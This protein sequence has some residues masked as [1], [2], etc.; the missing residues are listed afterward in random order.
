VAVEVMPEG[1]P[2][3]WW[4][5]NPK[6]GCWWLG[7]W[8]GGSGVFV[9]MVII[10]SKLIIMKEQQVRKNCQSFM[11]KLQNTNAY[12]SVK[13]LLLCWKRQEK[14]HNFVAA[15]DAFIKI[16]RTVYEFSQEEKDDKLI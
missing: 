8:E 7:D 11:N 6:G 4:R 10:N 15:V 2:G 14:Q 5:G 13:E 3:C 12:D 1:L 16:T 9:V